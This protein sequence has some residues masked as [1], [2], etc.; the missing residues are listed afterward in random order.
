MTTLTQLL[1]SPKILEKE[2]IN[3]EAKYTSDSCEDKLLL[4]YMYIR[5]KDLELIRKALNIYRSLIESDFSK[6]CLFYC[7]YCHYLLGDLY[8][9]KMW[10]N[11]LLKKD[12]K[13]ALANELMHHIEKELDKARSERKKNRLEKHD[14]SEMRLRKSGDDMIN[15][16]KVSKQ[17]FEYYS[18]CFDTILGKDKSGKFDAEN[19]QAACEFFGTGSHFV[20]KHFFPLFERKLNAERMKMEHINEHLMQIS[21]ESSPKSP[22]SPR[23][24]EQ[25]T[26]SSIPIQVP[27]TQIDTRMAKSWS[28]GLL[29]PRPDPPSQ[30]LKKMAPPILQ[31]DLDTDLTVGSLKTRTL[32]NSTSDKLLSP[33]DSSIPNKRRGTVAMIYVKKQQLARLID[34]DQ[35]LTTMVLMTSNT[36]TEEQL[37]SCFFA[38]DEEKHGF[39]TV[40]EFTRAITSV[41][42]ICEL[43]GLEPCADGFIENIW[44]SLDPKGVCRLTRV[45]FVERI[46][47]MYSELLGLGKYMGGKDKTV[48]SSGLGIPVLFG[49][50]F[51][52]ALAI[53]IGIQRVA[54]MTKLIRREATPDDFSSET[55]LSIRGKKYSYMEYC[56]H[57]FKKIRAAY[58]ITDDEYLV[59]IGF[60][61][62][63]MNLFLGKLTCYWEQP[64]PGRSGAWF[65]FTYDGKF[66]IKSIPNREAVSFKRAFPDYYKYLMRNPTTLIIKYFGCFE[67]NGENFL[68]MKNVFASPLP[69]HEIYDLKGS[70]FA[71]TNPNGKVKKDNDFKTKIDFGSVEKT[72]I[73]LRN[74]MRDIEFLNDLKFI[75]YSLLV[76][77]HTIEKGTDVTKMNLGDA[78]VSDNG[79][80]VYYIGIIDILTEWSLKKS[81]ELSFKSLGNLTKAKEISAQPPDEYS[82]RLKKFI[83]AKVVKSYDQ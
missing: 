37:S 80:M 6:D 62:F 35:F 51:S 68:V 32:R 75:D 63:M 14:L 30:E 67:L 23:S 24:K 10:L 12:S 56:P 5:T 26:N 41:L 82:D 47:T 76:G 25:S 45:E 34:F 17:E 27:K 22:R 42:E 9:C 58:G 81:A 2:I 50:N 13:H 4:A 74:T 40:T 29:P 19:L 53:M 65:F 72:R 83:I 3:A 16:S 54:E 43:M 20:I 77:I 11:K 31:G 73:F 33:E 39:V 79:K 48:P 36:A 55:S 1:S 46:P 52:P 71:R 64:T 7:A 70:T 38:M 49:E 66:M 78:I 15:L 28:S 44:K 8:D 59:S 18:D 57:L 69:M 61:Q 21:G 60:E